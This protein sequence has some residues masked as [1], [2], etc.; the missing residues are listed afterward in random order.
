MRK[1]SRSPG[2]SSSSSAALSA[3]V[4]QI[5]ALSLSHKGHYLAYRVARHLSRRVNF[6][7]GFRSFSSFT[8]PLPPLITGSRWR[9]M[10]LKTRI[11]FVLLFGSL[12]RRRRLGW[13]LNFIHLHIW[14]CLKVLWCNTEET[15]SWGFV[16]RI[17]VF[18]VMA[19]AKITNG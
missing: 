16:V 3:K 12:G 11:S 2:C 7:K 19:K 18:K 8:H 15:A 1:V 14:S 13:N 4:M 17:K 9:I 10:T 6:S 5:K